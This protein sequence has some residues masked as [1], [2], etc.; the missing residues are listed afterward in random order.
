MRTFL[1]ICF[2]LSAALIVWTQLG[3]ALALAAFARLLA[4]RTS[5]PASAARPTPR[6]SRRSR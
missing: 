3:Y 1:E 5:A 4:P 2:W 6:R